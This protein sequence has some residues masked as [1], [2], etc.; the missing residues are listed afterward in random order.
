M[1]ARKLAAFRL[2][3]ETIDGLNI[4]KARD[5]VPTS[6]Q[7]RRAIQAWLDAKGVT[8]KAERKRHRKA[9]ALTAARTKRTPTAGRNRTP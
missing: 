1:T 4:V 3:T 7:V 8:K 2:D 5:G 6:E 9:P